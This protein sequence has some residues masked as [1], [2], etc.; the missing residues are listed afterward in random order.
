MSIVGDRMGPWFAQALTLSARRHAQLA[1][2]IAN[3]DTP[4]YVPKDVSFMDTLRAELRETS[5]ES[6]LERMPAQE[7]FGA[8]PRI[9]GNRVD[10]DHE[11][12]QLANSKIF[13]ELTVEA[14][15][16]RGAMLRYSIDEG[17]R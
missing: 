17:G 5:L 4:N 9:D 11:M 16:R 8:P 14:I 3:I 12:T 13:H 7:Q 10:L 6:G 1:A 2:N 15:S